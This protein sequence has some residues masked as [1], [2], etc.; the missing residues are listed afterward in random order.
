MTNI[1][2]AIAFGIA[3]LKS[4]SPTPDIDALYLMMQL[5]HVS[6][7]W[8]FL[9]AEDPLLEDQE[10]RYTFWIQERK[11][12]IPI[13]YLTSMRGFWTLDL[14]VNESV[15][16]PRPE[17]ELLVELALKYLDPQAACTIAELGTGS[18]AIALSLA[19]ERPN[20]HIDAI[21]ISE[22][23]L[24]IAQK[25]AKTFALQQIK[26]HHGSWCEAL[27]PQKTYDAIISNPP[28]LSTD[29]PHLAQGDL[30]FE[31]QGALVAGITGLEAYELIASSAKNHLKPGGLLI[32]EHGYQQREALAT[33]LREFGYEEI[34]VFDDDQRLPRAML[35]SCL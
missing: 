30:R 15:L 28:Y 18:G 31:P 3:A 26:F 10:A 17:T 14:Y 16:I 5:L 8:I 13:A 33:L 24:H 21:D 25:N 35:A 22:A 27:P 34:M 20:W 4:S 2:E 32:L 23:A 12:G 9:H 19:S 11:K 7:A 1:R 29:D 6:S